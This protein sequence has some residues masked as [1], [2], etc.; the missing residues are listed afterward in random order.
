M[1]RPREHTVDSY[2]PKWRKLLWLISCAEPPT[3]TPLSEYKLLPRRRIICNRSQCYRCW[4]HHRVTDLISTFSYFCV[5]WN[6]V[7]FWGK[8]RE[9]GYSS[10]L[11]SSFSEIS[12]RMSHIFLWFFLVYL[13]HLLLLSHLCI[14]PLCFPSVFA[15]SSVKPFNF[16]FSSFTCTLFFL[17]WTYLEAP[18]ILSCF[19][20]LLCEVTLC[21]F[22]PSC[23]VCVHLGPLHLVILVTHTE[24]MLTF[25]TC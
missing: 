21:L 1:L 25:L 3:Q 17:F 11:L 8:T 12:F 23:P 14:E 15:G 9:G 5:D 13:S 24:H 7:Q 2:S 22:D 10:P 20:L 6:C 18:V 16:F 4:V 19:V